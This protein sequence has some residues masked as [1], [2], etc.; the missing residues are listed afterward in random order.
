[1]VDLKTLQALPKP[2]GC[3]LEGQSSSWKGAMML[4]LGISRTLGFRWALVLGCCDGPKVPFM[5]SGI[6]SSL[7]GPRLC[8]CY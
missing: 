4:E 6:R 5:E 8:L 7:L 3:L 1:M 2:A